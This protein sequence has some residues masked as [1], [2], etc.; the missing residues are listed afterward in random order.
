MTVFLWASVLL[1]HS[2]C[3]ADITGPISDDFQQWL[4]TNGYQND[5]FVRADYG[6]QGSYGGK[7]S[8][9]D[10]VKNVPVIFIHGNSDAA[11]HL[12]KT[13]TGWTNSIQYF[14]DQG[15]TQAELYATSW[16]DT[17]TN[18]AAKRTHDCY[19]LTRL[20]RFI[21]A[22]LAYT[23][24]PKVSLITHSMGVTLGR[25][26]IKGGA[27][28]DNSVVCNLGTPLTSKVDVF[29]G[30]AGANYGLCNCEGTGVLEPTCNKQN[31]FW[32]GDSCDLNSLDCGLKPLPFPCNG[33]TYSNLLMG[34]NTDNIREASLVYSAWS[35]VDDL[36]LYGDQ[37]WGRP[38]SLIPTSVGKV[39]YKHYTHM[40]TKENTAADQYTMVV[41]KTLP[42]SDAIIKKSIYF[43]L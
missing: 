36:I 26:A 24:A 10:T 7:A 37:V 23:G 33:P 21:Q 11:L 25:K 34:M 40:Q 6:T 3:I 13:A 19:D 22:V 15:Y 18:N 42:S 29:L 12:S 28:V 8:V 9:A 43:T 17:N 1:V 16:G 41:K 14:L 2:L 30:L 31:G 5:D 32:P 38:T 39:V 27:V 4:N 35:E 20:R